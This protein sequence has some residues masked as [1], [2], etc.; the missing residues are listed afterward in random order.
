LPARKP[1]LDEPTLQIME[2][3]VRMT[4]KP[5]DEMKVGKRKTSRAMSPGKRKTKNR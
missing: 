3:M 4:P 5:H 2:R 1:D